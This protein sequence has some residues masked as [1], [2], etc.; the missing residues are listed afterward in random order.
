MQYLNTCEGE[1]ISRPNRFVALVKCKESVQE[2]H[3]NTTGRCSELLMPQAKVVLAEAGGLQRK[4]RYD[5]IA[6][7]KADRLV[8]IDS[9][10]ANRVFGEWLSAGNMGKLSCI[11]PEYRFLDSRLDFYAETEGDRHLFEVKGVT[12]EEGGIARFPDAPTLRGLKHIKA[13]ME[14]Q[15]RGYKAHIVF[16]VQ[17]Q[18]ALYMAPNAAMQPEFAALLREAAK[19][20]V[21]VFA[22]ECAVSNN[23][24]AAQN[25][26][27]VRL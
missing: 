22:L 10:A 1:F 19:R 3:V 20:G 11:K 24:I 2:C 17:F 14:A 5:L 6:A 26:L 16:I 21:D 25:R 15:A 4:T 23:S 8:N 13:L 9:Q 12:L 27:P 7:Y 18:G